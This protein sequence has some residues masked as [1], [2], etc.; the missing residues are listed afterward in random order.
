MNPIQKL[1]TIVFRKNFET[2]MY[3]IGIDIFIFGFNS[4]QSLVLTPF[5][6][7]NIHTIPFLSAILYNIYV[8]PGNL[9][10]HTVT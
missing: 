3:S 7:Y 4:V 10:D 8:S 6:T 5:D 2:R 1:S 9:D